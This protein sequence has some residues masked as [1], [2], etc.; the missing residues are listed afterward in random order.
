MTAVYRSEGFKGGAFQS[1]RQLLFFIIILLLME[2]VFFFGLGK[3]TSA[4]R[5]TIGI[6]GEQLRTPLQPLN[7]MIL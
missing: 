5:E 2:A 6:M 7:T 1:L 4:V 3:L